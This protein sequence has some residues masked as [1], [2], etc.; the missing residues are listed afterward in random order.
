MLTDKQVEVLKSVSVQQKFHENC[1]Q[2][3]NKHFTLC[4]VAVDADVIAE[5]L[6][7]KKPKSKKQ[8]NIDIEK[9]HA[10]MEQT[11]SSGDLEDSGDGDSKEQE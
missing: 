9:E 1:V 11:H 6:G 3:D 7:I 2:G 5:H 10:D 4:K 8:I